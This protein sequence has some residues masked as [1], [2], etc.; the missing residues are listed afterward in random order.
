MHVDVV[1]H[2]AIVQLLPDMLLPTVLW[3]DSED[4]LCLKDARE[5]PKGI[6]LTAL[7]AAINL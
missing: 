3:S 5:S 2:D 7:Q 1:R 6:N 4:P